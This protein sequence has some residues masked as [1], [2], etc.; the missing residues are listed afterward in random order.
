M[1]NGLARAELTEATTA[2]KEAGYMVVEADMKGR[3]AL[4]GGGEAVF[5]WVAWR[6]ASCKLDLGERCANASRG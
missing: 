2:H 4:I 1:C 3:N 6:Q 5:W